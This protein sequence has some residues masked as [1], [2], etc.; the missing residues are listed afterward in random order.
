MKIALL[1]ISL[2]FLG[3]EKS[4][5]QTEEVAAKDYTS[6]LKK[7]EDNKW[8]TFCKGCTTSGKTY[9]VKFV[10]TCTETLTVKLAVQENHKRWKTYS[11]QKLMPNDT[12]SGF[13]CIGTGKYLFWAKQSDDNTVDLPTDEEINSQYAK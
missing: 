11:R 9:R 2:L 6:C 3:S 10:N 5:F 1:F 4:N 7:V 12:I 8:G 13:A